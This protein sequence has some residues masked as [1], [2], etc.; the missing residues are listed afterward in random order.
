M[1]M[2]PS[3]TKSEKPTRKQTLTDMLRVRTVKIIDPIVTFLAKYHVSPDL[4]TVGGMLSHFLLA[5]LVAIGEMRWA[6]IA[7]AILAPLDALDGSLA[8][9]LGRK[10]GGFGAYLDSTLDRMAEIILFGGFIYYYMQLNDTA[11][12]GLSYLAVS[13]S[14]MVSYSRAKA[15]SLGMEAKVGIASRV[16]RYV[17]MLVLLILDYPSVAI[18]LLAVTT[19]VTVGQRMYYV[20][21]QYYY[22]AN[23]EEAEA[24]TAAVVEPDVLVE[25]VDEPRVG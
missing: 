22:L 15:E 9:K 12:L 14:L 2:E 11:M 4:L 20:W 3:E 7:M 8:R 19:Y 23:K 1:E 13:G 18:V 21:Y 25:P 17:L 16:E 6:G 5:Y 24:V 10:Q